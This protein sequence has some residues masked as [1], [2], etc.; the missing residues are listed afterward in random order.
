MRLMT[1]LG[2]AIAALM[3]AVASQHPAPPAGVRTR[4]QALVDSGK[5]ASI[6]V[7]VG[8]DGGLL[9][10]DAVGMADKARRI[11]ATPRTP[12]SVASVTKPFT[13]TAVM[14]LSER[15]L[16]SLDEP[17]TRYL[18][19]LARPGVRSEREVTVRRV[20]GHTAGLPVHY[21]FFYADQPLAPLPFAPR[22]QCYGAEVHAPGARY[23]Y[24]NL[25]YGVLGDLVARVAETTYGE[26]LARE[27]FAPLGLSGARVP[28]G[29]GDTAGFAVRYDSSGEPL[30]FYVTDHPAASELYV[31]VEDLVRFG[32]FHAGAITP[33][34]V[35][36]GA[37]S[38]AAMQQPGLGRYG[39]GWSVNPDWRGRRVV[40]HGG[41]MPGVSA[42]LWVVP[43]ERIAIALASNQMGAPVNQI[44]GEILGDLLGVAPPGGPGGGADAEVPAASLPA[45]AP[46]LRGR[47]QGTLSSCPNATAIALEVRGPDDIGVAIGSGPAAA[48]MAPSAADGRVAGAFAGDGEMGPSRFRFT[49]ELRGDRLEGPVAR[50]TSLGARGNTAVALWAS[51]ERA[52]E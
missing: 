48:A 52:P 49:L 9:W 27:L 47:W 3:A 42:T 50:A 43:G 30:P 25:G 46:D 14:M 20:L 5:V 33:A 31:S 1:S 19:P 51:L 16:V 7:A 44:A 21:Q 40:Y 4:L 2:V 22:M 45:T 26:F 15:G 36:L 18:G 34:R 37:G 38:R 32:L 29:M 12:Y 6:A 39:L 41:G 23:A 8:R 10:S 28:A 11:A 35:V 17:I 13:A 24:S